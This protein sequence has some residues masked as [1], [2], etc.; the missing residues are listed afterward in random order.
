MWAAPPPH[1]APGVTHHP[2]FASFN[3]GRDSI[4]R[5]I[6]MPDPVTQKSIPAQPVHAAFG[7]PECLHSSLAQGVPG[8]ELFRAAPC[9]PTFMTVSTFRT[10]GCPTLLNSADQTD[11]QS[12]DKP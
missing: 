7:I 11:G 10:S 8:R 9:P 1:D 2:F 5:I 12:A 4:L 6:D 3:E